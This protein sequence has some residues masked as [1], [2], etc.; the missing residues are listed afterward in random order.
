[1]VTW[2]IDFDGR[3]FALL[4]VNLDMT[5]RLLDEAV[6]LGEAKARALSDVFG[7]KERIER[8]RFHL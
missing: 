8:F 4:T 5:A 1:M 7:R 3:A 2:Q 6:D